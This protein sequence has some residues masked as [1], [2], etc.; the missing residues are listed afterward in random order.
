[1][2]KLLTVIISTFVGVLVAMWL[3]R[4]LVAGLVIAALLLVL[5]FA[6]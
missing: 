4:Q 2:Q 3:F 1:M 5:W 6:F